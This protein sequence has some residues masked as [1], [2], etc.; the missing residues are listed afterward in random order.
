MSRTT[1]TCSNAKSQ[2]DGISQSSSNGQQSTFKRN[3]LHKNPKY[4]KATNE[5]EWKRTQVDLLVV[6]EVP[7][8]KCAINILR[9][10]QCTSKQIVRETKRYDHHFLFVCLFIC[11]FVFAAQSKWLTKH[12]NPLKELN[13]HFIEWQVHDCPKLLEHKQTSTVANEFDPAGIA[14]S[15]NGFVCAWIEYIICIVI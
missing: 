8:G 2:N 6:N 9:P 11:L 4:K 1:E 7:S 3:F 15:I 12:E 13:A 10:K 5:N 14:C